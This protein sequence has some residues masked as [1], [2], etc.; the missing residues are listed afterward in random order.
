MDQADTWERLSHLLPESDAQQFQDCWD[1]GEQEAGLDRLVGGL[2]EQ[3]T[4]IND[5]VRAEIS[6]VAET[7]GMREALTPR[8]LA[9]PGDGSPHTLELIDPPDPLHAVPDPQLADL[10]LVPWIRCVN[11]GRLLIRAHVEEPWGDLS[12]IAEHYAVL[13]SERGP[14]VRLFEAFSAGDALTEL[15]QPSVS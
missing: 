9:C 8:L 10:V 12:L 11:S 4:A 1:T 14:L 3:Q 13:A 2:L 7:W 15:L 6:V 5:T